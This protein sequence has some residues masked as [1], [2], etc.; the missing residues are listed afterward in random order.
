MKKLGVITIYVP[1]ELGMTE[2]VRVAN[3][4]ALQEDLAEMETTELGHAFHIMVIE[5]PTRDKVEVSV[6]FNPFTA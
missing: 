3:R 2:E 4:R 6:N 5:D 1:L